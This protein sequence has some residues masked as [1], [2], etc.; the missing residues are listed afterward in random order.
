MGKLYRLKRAEQKRVFR[1]AAKH[2]GLVIDIREARKIMR[3][4]GYKMTEYGE[5][6]STIRKLTESEIIERLCW[7]AT[8]EIQQ[9]EDERVF[10]ELAAAAAPL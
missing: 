4:P 10:A 1:A 8:R 3:D 6:R 5:L 7:K 9:M 2:L